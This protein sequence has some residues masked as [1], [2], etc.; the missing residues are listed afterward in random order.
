MGR[1]RLPQASCC[2]PLMLT[3]HLAFL[4]CFN[5]PPSTNWHQ[6]SAAADSTSNPLL[7]SSTFQGIQTDRRTQANTAFP[8]TVI[9]PESQ[10]PNP[11]WE[12]L[13]T[14][15]RLRKMC[16][17]C[18]MIFSSRPS[19]GCKELISF[20]SKAWGPASLILLWPKGA[21]AGWGIMVELI[22]CLWNW[23][24]QGGGGKKAVKRSPKHTST[25]ICQL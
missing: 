13:P 24:K 15:L 9:L 16:F 23:R 21:L 18:L 19:L 7:S 8:L 14:Y 1:R 20:L 10:N 12:W 3:V 22:V 5:P 2:H 6:F 4:N 25:K 11:P 17:A